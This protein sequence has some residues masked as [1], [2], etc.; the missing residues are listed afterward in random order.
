MVFRMALAL[1]LRVA[2]AEHAEEHLARVAFQRQRLI[3]RAERDHAARLTA[4][5]QRRQRRVLAEVPRRDLVDRDADAGLGVALARAHAVQP[6][7]LDDAV[8]AAA[9][10]ALVAQAADHRHVVAHRFQRLED[11]REVEVAAGARRRPLILHRAVREVDE[12]QARRG[13]RGGLRQ[14]RA[15]RDHGVQQRQRDGRAGALQDGAPRQMLA[16][17]EHD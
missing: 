4:Q 8:R 11:E 6:G 10:A 16:G 2:L 5:L 14:R 3:R 15:G 13:G 17:Q 9:L 12:A 1:F 7:L